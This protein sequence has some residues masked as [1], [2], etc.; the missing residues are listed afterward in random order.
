MLLKLRDPDTL[1]DLED[2]LQSPD[3]GAIFALADSVGGAG[4]GPG[5]SASVLIDLE[6]GQYMAVCVIPDD[7]G[8][9]HYLKGQQAPFSVTENDATNSPPS[10]DLSVE[11]SEMVFTG[12]SAE[13]PSGPQ[14]WEVTNTGEQLHELALVRLAD[15]MTIDQGFEIFGIGAEAATPDDSMASMEMEGPPFTGVGGI[16]PLG[17]GQTNLLELDL[18]PGTYIAICFVPDTASGA[19][20]FMLGMISGFTVA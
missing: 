18:A 5:S 11:M 14:I 17:P 15:G 2:V 9:P 20:H 10:A 16:A 19:P 12:I 13:L 1:A 3:F 6:P 8:T 4:A 7:D